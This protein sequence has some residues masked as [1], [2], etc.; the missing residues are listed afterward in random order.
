MVLLMQQLIMLAKFWKLDRIRICIQQMNQWQ[1][2][3]KEYSIV[4]NCI[5][6]LRKFLFSFFI[7]Y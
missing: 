6:L 5:M 4:F 3:K 1:L 7:S 2:I